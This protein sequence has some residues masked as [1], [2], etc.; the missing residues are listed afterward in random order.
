MELGA[1][2][3]Q[4]RQARRL[5]QQALAKRANVERTYVSQLETGSARNPSIVVLQ[6]LAQALGLGLEDLLREAGLI[7]P[8]PELP[9]VLL[10]SL[11]RFQKL[12]FHEQEIIAAG[13]HAQVERAGLLVAGGYR[14]VAEEE[15]SEP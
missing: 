15:G 2:I 13:F 3:R 12:P 5:S 9:T 10:V 4:L 6:N 8:P 11:K 7:K 14:R 1:V